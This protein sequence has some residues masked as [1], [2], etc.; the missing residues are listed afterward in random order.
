M[1]FLQV[2]LVWRSLF[3]GLGGARFLIVGL[4]DV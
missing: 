2:E 3:Q 4:A 1:A